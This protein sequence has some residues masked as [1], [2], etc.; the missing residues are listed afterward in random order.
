MHNSKIHNTG[1]AWWRRCPIAVQFEPLGLKVVGSFSE[2]NVS[3]L[4][5]NIMDKS[6]CT[7]VYAYQNM[8]TKEL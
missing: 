8:Y 4:D 6:L 1:L 2:L 3:C 5:G 7:C